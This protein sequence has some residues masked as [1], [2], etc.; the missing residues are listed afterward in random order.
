M[1]WKQ[2]YEAAR[3]HILRSGSST[4]DNRSDLL[5]AFQT[6]LSALHEPTDEATDRAIITNAANYILIS[7]FQSFLSTETLFLTQYFLVKK[8]CFILH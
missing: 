6:I 7:V 4:I 2:L 5:P 3:A 1:I 8:G